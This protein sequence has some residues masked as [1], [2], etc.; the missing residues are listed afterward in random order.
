MLKISY[1]IT[2]IFNEILNQTV[3]NPMLLDYVVIITN[4]GFI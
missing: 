1:W 4:W 3:H 2:S